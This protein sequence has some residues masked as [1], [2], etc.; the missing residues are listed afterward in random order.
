MI[1]ETRDDLMLHSDLARTLLNKKWSAGRGLFHSSD[2]TAAAE[3]T[4]NREGEL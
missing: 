2:I 1:K 4:R 3:R